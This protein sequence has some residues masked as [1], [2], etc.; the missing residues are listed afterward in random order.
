MGTLTNWCPA[1]LSRVVLR[2]ASKLHSDLRL[3]VAAFQA[4]LPCHGLQWSLA[5]AKDAGDSGWGSGDEEVEVSG[6]AAAKHWSQLRTASVSAGLD[7]LFIAPPITSR[8]KLLVLPGRKND[9]YIPVR[10]VVEM[11]LKL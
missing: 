7:H 2:L 6:L 8:F 11:R 5:T 1:T 4:S 9:R 3:N 10:K